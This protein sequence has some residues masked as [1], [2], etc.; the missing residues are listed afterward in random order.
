MNVSTSRI[1]HEPSHSLLHRLLTQF[2]TH[3]GLPTAAHRF[4][5]ATGLLQSTSP[6][7]AT[8]FEVEFCEK[9]RALG[10][11]DAARELLTW[12][13]RTPAV[14]YVLSRVWLDESRYEDAAAALEILGGSFGE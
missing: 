9:L 6:A 10:Y 1:Q 5:D 11:R 4:I 3:G 8:E 2:R 13:P 12:L 14:S 7:L